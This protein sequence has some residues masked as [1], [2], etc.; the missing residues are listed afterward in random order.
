MRL[1]G[2]LED[3]V[4]HIGTLEGDKVAPLGATADF[5]A[6]PELTTRSQDEP[7]SLAG[8][9]QAPPVPVTSRIF[10]VGINYR[11]HATESKEVAGLDVPKFPMIFGRW[12][13]SLVVDGR[14][15][16]VPPNEK[17]LD[18]EAELAVVIK[19]KVWAADEATAL[20]HVLGYTAFNDLS[21][22]QKQLET[23]Q[24]T[25]GKNADRSGPI[26]PVL[27][28]ADEIGDPS[29]LRVTAHVNGELVQDG[30]TRDLIHT[31]PKIIAYITDTVTLLP[32]DVIAT[33]T[34]G[35]VGI[36]RN[37]VWLLNDGDEVTVEIE[38][39]GVLRTPIV[40]R[41]RLISQ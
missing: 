1:I 7:R 34:P 4:R 22:R 18:W 21:A 24:F 32:G 15:V 23:S 8:L 37:P 31:V 26:G 14:P 27:V 5:Y 13:Q 28:T 36:G 11:S 41:D 3:G 40:S 10:C 19:D 38:K 33:G 35:G 2:Y 20:D 6:N 17:G 12:E 25:L 39:I 29:G 9:A 16:P 30:N